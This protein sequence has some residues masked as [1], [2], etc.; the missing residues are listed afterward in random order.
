MEQATTDINSGM[1][2]SEQRGNFS[3]YTVNEDDSRIK[4]IEEQIN[5]QE[6]SLPYFNISFYF[7][8]LWCHLTLFIAIEV[9]NSFV[10]RFI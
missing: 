2:V 8:F 3:S 5:K 10:L 9:T 4:S 6:V 1:L 7:A